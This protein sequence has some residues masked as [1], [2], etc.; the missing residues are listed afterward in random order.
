M[1][2]QTLGPC[3]GTET[4]TEGSVVGCLQPGLSKNHHLLKAINQKLHTMGL[5]SK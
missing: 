1:L 2:V 3:E 5:V 4:S